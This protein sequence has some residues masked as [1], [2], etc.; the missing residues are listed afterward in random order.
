MMN[1]GAALNDILHAV[2]YPEHLLQRPY[3]R[4][5]Y[6]EPEFIVHNL[7]RLYGGWWDGNPAHLKPSP[8]S[9][10]AQ[11]LASL[12]GGADKLA[13]RAQAV[14]ADGDLRLASHLIELAYRASSEADAIR[15]IR[16]EIYKLRV[17]AETS[18]MAKG[19]FGHVVRQSGKG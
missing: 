12:A 7:W 8:D 6:D 10:V 3:L 13:A 4:A 19:I 17:A 14:A 18:L 1:Q 16:T 5:V 9:A 15:G 2:K 11:E